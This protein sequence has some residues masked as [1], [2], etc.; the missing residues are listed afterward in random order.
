MQRLEVLAELVVAA[1]GAIG[2]LDGVLVFPDL[3]ENL[4]ARLVSWI[5]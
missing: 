1:P 4:V 5:L 3:T 2:R